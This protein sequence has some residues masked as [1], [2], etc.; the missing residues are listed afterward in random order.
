MARTSLPK[1]KV[2]AEGQKP[3]IDFE[4]NPRYRDYLHAVYRYNGNITAAEL[5]HLVPEHRPT[6]RQRAAVDRAHVAKSKKRNAQLE[7]NNDAEPK[8]GQAAGAQT[9]KTSRVVQAHLSKLHHNDYLRRYGTRNMVLYTLGPRAL[10]PLVSYFDA[11]PG[12]IALLQ[13]RS[14]EPGKYYLNHSRMISRI[15]FMTEMAVRDTAVDIGFWMHDGQIK[16]EVTFTDSNQKS[17]S[18]PVIP[19]AFFALESKGQG[20]P[21]FICLEADRT[22]ST[23]NRFLNKMIGYYR[24]WKRPR[25]GK[26]L[27]Q[28]VL[29][30]SHFRVLVVCV[31][32]PRCRGL[33]NDTQEALRHDPVYRGSM[34]MASRQSNDG[35]IG[36]SSGIVF[37]HMDDW[38]DERGFYFPNMNAGM[39]PFV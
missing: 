11:D 4:G 32:I 33:Y 23:R 25:R 6:D 1:F 8:A 31:S 5:Q 39:I 28:E 17:K 14:R 3:P 9:T 7:L 15:H 20:Q 34:D 35:S 26:P 38:Q 2:A 21:V 19:D 10:E 27:C 37:A 29:E 13:T 24:F 30:T 22:S 18:I 36:A 12:R 16:S